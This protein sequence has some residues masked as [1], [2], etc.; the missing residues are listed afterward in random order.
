TRGTRGTRGTRKQFQPLSNYQL[1]TTN[2][3]LPTT[4]YQ[5][6]ITNSQNHGFKTALQLR[7]QFYR[8]V[9]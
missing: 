4:N 5:L 1:P 3:Q 9:V 8:A 2:Y 6:P 7:T